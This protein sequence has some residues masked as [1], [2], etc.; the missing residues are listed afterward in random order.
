M[1]QRI[2]DVFAQQ[3]FMTTLGATIERVESG[4]VEVR[5]PFQPALTQHTGVLHAGVVTSIADS[6]CAAAAATMMAPDADVVSV[7]FK[8]NLMRPSIGDYL[9]AVGTVVH[10]GRT[11]AVCRADVFAVTGEDAS[12]VAVMQATMMAVTPRS[13]P[14][15][16]SA[17]AL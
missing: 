7:E 15:S 13:S 6:A 8:L 16:Q 12:L 1:Q 4:V 17:P 3:S 2:R 11:L 10:A 5:L 14:P 9:R